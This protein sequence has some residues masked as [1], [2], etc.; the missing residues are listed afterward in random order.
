VEVV[1]GNVV[2]DL[3]HQF[4]HAA[5]RTAP[6]R[7]WVMIPNLRSTWLSECHCGQGIERQKQLVRFRLVDK[8][9]V[10]RS[11]WC[12]DSRQTPQ[13]N[14]GNHHSF[15]GRQKAREQFA[16]DRSKVP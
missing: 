13:W 10:V 14:G 5:K 3:L 7:V 12:S 1:A 15:C 2:I 8:R 6:D 4:A 16:P 9:A 11:H